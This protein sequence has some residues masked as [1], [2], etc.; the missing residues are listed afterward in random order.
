MFA[1]FLLKCELKQKSCVKVVVTSAEVV[2]RIDL[3]ERDT[4]AI[5]N[6]VLKPIFVSIRI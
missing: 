5:W 3:P 6:G 2:H 1:G 4:W